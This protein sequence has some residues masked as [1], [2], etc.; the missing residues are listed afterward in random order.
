MAA[1]I[2]SGDEFSHD[3]TVRWSDCDPA[4]IAYTGRIPYFALEAIDAWWLQTIGADWFRQNVDHGIGT[5][6]VHLSMDFR[7]P[8][9]P[10]HVLTCTVKLL[11][12]GESSI[13]FSVTGYQDS[14][15]CFEGEFVEVFV[16]ASSMTKRG[17]PEQFR[18]RLSDQLRQQ[19]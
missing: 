13:R 3:I 12:L 2:S 8:I 10:R 17:I 16:D 4:R 15:L 7:H 1:P 6:F 19:P 5:P 14:R 11:R 9:T 18:G